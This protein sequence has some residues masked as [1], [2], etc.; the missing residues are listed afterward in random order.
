MGYEKEGS[1]SKDSQSAITT[2][3]SKILIPCIK[4][5]QT[6][7]TLVKAMKPL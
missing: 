7:I 5:L 2:D 6:F 1:D 4:I 3:T